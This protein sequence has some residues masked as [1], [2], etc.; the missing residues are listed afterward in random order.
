MESFWVFRRH[1]SLCFS[2]ERVFSPRCALARSNVIRSIYFIKIFQ[3]RQP[4]VRRISGQYTSLQAGFL[5]LCGWVFHNGRG[6]IVL[7]RNKHI[8][9]SIFIKHICT[10][11]TFLHA[12][13]STTPLLS[14]QRISPL[15]FVGINKHFP[16]HQA[17]SCM[18]TQPLAWKRQRKFVTHLTQRRRGPKIVQ[19]TDGQEQVIEQRTW[20]LLPLLTPPKTLRACVGPSSLMPETNCKGD[21]V[22]GK[23]HNDMR[24]CDYLVS[25]SVCSCVLDEPV[26]W[27]RAVLMHLGL[28]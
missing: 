12:V 26:I 10:S 2:T 23:C 5:V 4:W 6:H 9:T 17:R 28:C 8:H 20:F 24:C 21:G 22:V 13:D 7:L 27:Q 15:R 19:Y 11:Y 14:A 18:S 16:L 1:S 3:G 25:R